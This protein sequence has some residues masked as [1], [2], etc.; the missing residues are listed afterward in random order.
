MTTLPVI[1]LALQTVFT[2]NRNCKRNI[3]PLWGTSTFNTSTIPPI[4]RRETILK[5]DPILLNKLTF[6]KSHPI[7]LRIKKQTRTINHL[8]DIPQNVLFPHPIFSER[9]THHDKR[10]DFINNKSLII[11]WVWRNIQWGR[12]QPAKKSLNFGAGLYPTLG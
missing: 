7:G 9:K 1:I 5:N 6:Q 12:D 8:R 11:Q 10:N 4:F 2:K 3:P